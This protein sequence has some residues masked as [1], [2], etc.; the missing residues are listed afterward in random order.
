MREIP[1][2]LMHGPF[3]LERALALGLSREVVNGPRFRTPWRG[4]RVLRN[5]PD[6]LEQRCR[7]ASLVF[8]ESAVFSHDTAVALGEWLAPR[9]DGRAS[10]KY[11][12]RAVD[13][14][15]PVHVS[16]PPHVP[17]PVGRGVVGHRF[18]PAVEDVVLLDGLRVTSPWRTWCDLAVAGAEDADLVI[19]ADALRRRFPGAGAR[20][21]SERLDAWGSGRGARSLLRALARSR[22]GVDSPM[23]T[24]LRL[25]FVDAGLP[26][27]K[28]NQWVR[29]EDGTPIHRP[30][31]SWPQWRVAADYDGVHHAERDDEG[32]VRAGRHS[33]WRQRQDNSRRDLM[34]DARWRL[35]VFTSF[36]VFRRQELSVE[37]MRVTLREAGAPV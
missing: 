16:V 22:D 21:L 5:T 32:V 3:T 19:L 35:R 8:P 33:D 17:R 26:E 28:V 13:P 31:L 14:D 37:R 27:P 23:E 12:P 24:R 1:D 10:R 2:E 29:L 6:T 9:V 7:A 30:D 36:D 4:V 25:L 20:L 11:V 18:D 34:E 15:V